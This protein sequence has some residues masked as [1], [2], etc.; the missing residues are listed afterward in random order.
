M[1]TFDINDLQKAFNSPMF[2]Q[3]DE[4]IDTGVFDSIDV[5]NI[6]IE[7]IGNEAEGKAK[8]LIE[9]LAKFYYDEEFLKSNPNFRKRV[10]NDIES[11]RMLLKMRAADEVTHDVLIKAIAAN[12]GNA[13][14]YGSLTRIQ[15]AM[16]QITTKIEAIV[17]NLTTMIKG[18]Q[19]EL[20]FK[21]E[22][23]ALKADSVDEEVSVENMNTTHRGTKSF[24][25]QMNKIEY[26]TEET[27]FENNSTSVN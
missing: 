24:I 19:L 21:Y 15:Q 20:N 1:N 27:L 16:L 8:S 14:L 11:L 7:A 10:D 17:N 18:Y 5:V 26:T 25:E 9:D 6:D 3:D 22:Q 13:S 4:P 23:E 12:S 2:A